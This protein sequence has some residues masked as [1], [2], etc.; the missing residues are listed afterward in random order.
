VGPVRTPVIVRW[1]AIVL[2]FAVPATLSGCA[3]SRRPAG[4]QTTTGSQLTGIVG[5][6]WR[7]TEVQH[8]A[9]KVT[10]PPG[11]GGYFALT[12][13]GGLIAD[14]TIN[15]YAGRF[16]ETANGYHVTI[17]QGTA[18]GYGGH[19]PVLLALIEGT[20]ALTDEGAD[21]TARQTS[22][23][24]ELSTGTYHI[25]ATRVGPTGVLPSPIPS[26]TTSGS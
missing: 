20:Q 8:G 9:A 11:R 15:N 17:M 3:S 22:T 4:T 12:Q 5:F 14:D 18:V 13:D 24:L 25:T 1:I 23:R 19:D 2:A 16:T 6:R 10:V 21:V 7:I 26:P